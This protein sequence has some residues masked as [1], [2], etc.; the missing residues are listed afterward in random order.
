VDGIHFLMQDGP[1]EVICRIT[2]E[3]LSQLGQALGLSEPNEIFA[4]GRDAIEHAASHKY[5]R[6]SRRSYEVLIITADDLS[7]GDA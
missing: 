7:L 3:A 6:T 4:A 2:V 1:I 5:D